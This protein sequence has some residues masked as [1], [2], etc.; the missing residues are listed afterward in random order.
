MH[1]TP[2]NLMTTASLPV[3]RPFFAYQHEWNSGARSRNRVLTKMHQAGADFFF[4]YEALND[5]LH[6]GRNQIFLGCTPASRPDS[7]NL[8]V[9]LY[10]SGRNLDTPWENKIR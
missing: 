4:A 10:R 5:A 9:S 2:T 1:S 6:T 7:Q 8:Y 3:D